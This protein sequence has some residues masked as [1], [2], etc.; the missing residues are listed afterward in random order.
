MEHHQDAGRKR[1]EAL[2]AMAKDL[3]REEACRRL[4]AAVEAEWQKPRAQQD[5]ALIDA[6]QELIACLLGAEQ[7]GQRAER[8]RALLRARVRTRRRR[9]CVAIAAMLMLC[10]P[11]ADKLLRWEGFVGSSTQDEQQYMVTGVAVDPGLVE[12][13]QADEGEVE[14][15]QIFTTDP[16]EAAAFYGETLPLPTWLPACVASREY[17]VLVAEG[18]AVWGVSYYDAQGE[19]VIGYSVDRYSDVAE[20]AIGFQQNSH[21][22]SVAVDGLDVYRTKNMAR[23]V[24]IWTQENCVHSLIGSVGIDDLYRVLKSL[25]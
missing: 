24:L 23:D 17:G 18:Y 15:R 1:I 13:A 8:P 4:D 19:V 16:E 9:A 20:A 6:C 5:M 11:V 7:N 10:M 2:R 14:T 3:T 12:R 25:Q 21:G 22:E